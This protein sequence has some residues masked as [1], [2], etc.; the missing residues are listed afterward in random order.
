[1]SKKFPKK[2]VDPEF[3]TA[4][5]GKDLTKTLMLEFF[6]IVAAEKKTHGHEF[7]YTVT[8]D[9]LASFVSTLVYN[10]LREGAMAPTPEMQLELTSQLFSAVKSDI[11]DAMEQAF[12]GAFQS[13]DPSSSPD[14]QCDIV[15]LDTG[16]ETGTTQ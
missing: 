9:F 13:F 2:L 1:M 7:A 8:M 6:K 10:T 4:A 16:Y 14:Y 5:Y 11:E 3:D 12:A 15:C